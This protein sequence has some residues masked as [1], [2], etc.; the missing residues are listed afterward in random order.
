MLSFETIQ[1][2]IGVVNRLFYDSKII[3]YF[4]SSQTK[5]RNFIKLFRVEIIILGLGLQKMQF[6]AC[7]FL[8]NVF[9]GK[10]NF[11]LLL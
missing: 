9:F 5:A 4:K 2:D 11:D 10:G 3:D 7:L 8:R 6:R 1:W